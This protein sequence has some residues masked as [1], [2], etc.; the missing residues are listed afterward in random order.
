MCGIFGLI[1]RERGRDYGQLQD[2]MTA[3]QKHRGPDATGTETIR[4]GEMNIF[5]HHSRLAINGDLLPQPITNA[6]KTI[7]L[8][9]N[10]E[11]F[12]W[13]ALEEELGYKCSQSD[14]EILIP[15]YQAHKHELEVFFEKIEGQF[16]FMLYDKIT[17]CVLIGR[18]RIGVTPLYVGTKHDDASFFCV[19]SEMKCLQHAMVGCDEVRVFPPR[20]FLHCGIQ[21]VSSSEWSVYKSYFSPVYCNPTGG[22]GHEEEVLHSIH[23]KLSASVRQQL[24]DLVCRDGS[25]EFGVLLSGGLDSSLIASLVVHHARD[26]GYTQPVRTFSVGVNET[27]PDLV[28]ARKV[29]EHLGTE[30]TEFY[31]SVAEG[32]RAVESVIWYI[33]SYDC[34]T[35]RASTPMYLLAKNIKEKH[36]KMKVLFSGELSDE[37]LCYLYGAN[38]PSPDEFQKETLRLVSKVHLFDCLRSNKTCMAHS[39]EVRV[40]FTD[41][42]Y[43]DYILRLHP[44]WKMFGKD[45]VMEKAILRKAFEGWLP[46]DILY[47]KKEQFSDGVSGF[48]GAKDNWIDG[49]KAFCGQLYD[50]AS[51]EALS[52]TFQVNRPSTKEQL[53]YRQMFAR[54]FSVGEDTVCVWEPKWS[55]TTDPSGRVQTFWAVN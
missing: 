47:R 49:V 23:G 20:Q 18:D 12:N 22:K 2:A 37:L 4:E 35:V 27:V 52:K 31:F 50:D 8:V 46:D 24:T 19:A 41:S 48:N 32:L 17:Q 51:F 40:P 39:M 26:L 14:C 29:A 11:I 30:H 33:E 21:D 42:E 45:G 53:W 7:L 10:G 13:K 16:S 5:F 36:P 38:A 55:A 43:V 15:L 6:A 28:A 44:R 34:T 25:I 1:E 9:I 54:L 3:L